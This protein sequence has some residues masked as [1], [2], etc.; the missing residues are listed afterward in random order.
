MNT[1]GSPSSRRRETQNEEDD[2]V[3][4]WKNARYKMSKK[5]STQQALAPLKGPQ[6]VT[7]EFNKIKEIKKRKRSNAHLALG[8]YLEGPTSN[9][10]VKQDSMTLTEVNYQLLRQIEIDNGNMYNQLIGRINQFETMLV[11]ISSMMQD[12]NEH[13]LQM[14]ESV[15]P[16]TR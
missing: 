1:L 10:L 16:G 5:T 2:G 3:Q 4:A 9:I 13:Q 7:N 14:R 11:E 15:E 6:A 8:G 12:L